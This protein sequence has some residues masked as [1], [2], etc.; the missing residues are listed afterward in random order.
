MISV[1]VEA[2]IAKGAQAKVEMIVDVVVEAA[3]EIE[4]IVDL[5]L[6]IVGADPG[7]KKEEDDLEAVSAIEDQGVGIAI[8]DLVAVIDED[9]IVPGEN[10]FRP[11]KEING[12]CFVC[13]S[14]QEFNPEILKISFHRSARSK[15]FA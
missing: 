3:V 13:N 5:V 14:R 1:G 9:M 6:V 10:M 4:E 12:L 8:E 15:R 7:V 11:K 2:K